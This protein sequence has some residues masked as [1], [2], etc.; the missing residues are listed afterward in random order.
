MFLKI[1]NLCPIFE[2]ISD[3]FSESAGLQDAILEFHAMC[4]TFCTSVLVLV[5]K[6]GFYLILSLYERAMFTDFSRGL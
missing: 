3:I 4:I 5:R 2:Q 1:G 6:S